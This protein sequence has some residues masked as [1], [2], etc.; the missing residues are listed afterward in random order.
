MGISWFSCAYGCV[1]NFGFC[2]LYLH[3]LCHVAS[4]LYIL[5]DT[6]TYI[7]EKFVLTLSCPPLCLLSTYISAAST[8]QTFVKFDIIFM[9]IC[10]ENKNLATIRMKISGALHEVISTSCS[11]QQHKFAI[12]AL[13]CNTQHF[14]IVGIDM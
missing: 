13:F 11:C 3:R 4:F 5:I 6:F 12:E 2:P 14:Y 1:I 7:C 10:W 9:K 8:G